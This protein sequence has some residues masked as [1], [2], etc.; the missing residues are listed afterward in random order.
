VPPKP[1]DGLGDEEVRLRLSQIHLV[2][3][4]S[5]FDYYSVAGR[6]W[7]NQDH[8]RLRPI[9]QLEWMGDRLVFLEENQWVAYWGI[10]KEDL[11]TADPAVWQGVNCTPL[12]WCRE[13]LCLSR[14]LMAMWKWT[15]T[16]EQ[17]MPEEV[18]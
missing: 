18:G 5:L 17:D 16:G 13:N 1:S 15:V 6:H 7:I 2:I 14:F 11:K 4:T 3:P 9:E 10:P 12:E 8:N